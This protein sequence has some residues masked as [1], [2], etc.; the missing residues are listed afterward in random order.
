[1]VSDDY[2]DFQND[3]IKW[4]TNKQITWRE[5]IIEGIENTPNAFLELLEGKNIGKMV[6]KI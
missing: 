5:T 4:I 3:M 6:G 1:M 2:E